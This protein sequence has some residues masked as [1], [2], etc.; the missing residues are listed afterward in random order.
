MRYL[1]YG[2]EL[3]RLESKHLELVRQWRNQE[4]IRLRMQY[5]EMIGPVAQAKWFNGLDVQNDWYFV[6][7]AKQTSFGL[8]HVKNVRW[9][10]KA[11]EAGG[12]V[13]NPQ[14]IGGGPAGLAILAL[15]DF[16]FFKL[17]L[18]LLEA[19]YLPDCREIETLNLQ[20][21][22]EVFRYQSNGFVK[23]RVNCARFL[24]ATKELRKAAEQLGGE[25]ARLMD[26]DPWLVEHLRSISSSLGRG[27]ATRR[28]DATLAQLHSYH[29]V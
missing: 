18:E 19:T 17:G 9:E 29:S 10:K 24:T 5:K 28:T 15:M 26:A 27:I 22:Y 16:A 7:L 6:A 11:G 2:I 4:S 25:E 20:L 8:F 21:G 14:W 23:A 13:G 3:E 12:F 1:R